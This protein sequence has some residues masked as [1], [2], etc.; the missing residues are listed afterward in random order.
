MKTLPNVFF[1]TSKE[2]A[3]QLAEEMADINFAVTVRPDGN[4]FRIEVSEDFRNSQQKEVL[5][6]VTFFC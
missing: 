6:C 1:R 2:A 5:P 3:S 4:I